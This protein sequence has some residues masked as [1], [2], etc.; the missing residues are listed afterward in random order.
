DR[1]VVPTD[2]AELDGAVNLEVQELC[3]GARTSHGDLP[4]DP[5][6]LRALAATLGADRPAA[7]TRVS[8][9]CPWWRSSP[10]PRSGTPQGR[11]AGRAPPAPRHPTGSGRGT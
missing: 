1:I 7:P 2:T 4:G 9:G 10:T 5:V 6:T 8:C 11:R 3:P